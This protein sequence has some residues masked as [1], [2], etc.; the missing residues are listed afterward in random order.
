[1]FTRRPFS[2]SCSDIV[3]QGLDGQQR[4]KLASL[5]VGQISSLEHPQHN[6]MLR[7]TDKGIAA[8]HSKKNKNLFFEVAD[9][10]QYLLAGRKNVKKDSTSTYVLLFALDEKEGPG[11]VKAS[12]VHLIRFSD[13]EH[14]ND[15]YQ[16]V[17]NVMVNMTD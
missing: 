1:M 12:V 10:I 16:A 17:R 11:G 4:R 15:L 9:R 6:I 7:V 3:P 5:A 14:V 8:I 2:H 13:R